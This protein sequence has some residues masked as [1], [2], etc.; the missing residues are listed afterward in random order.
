MPSSHST[1][2]PFTSCP[3]SEP[4]VCPSVFPM[5]GR[6]ALALSHEALRRHKPQEQLGTA[7]TCFVPI[8]TSQTHRD[9]GVCDTATPAQNGSASRFSQTLHHRWGAVSSVHASLVE[10]TE[11]DQAPGSKSSAV[12]LSCCPAEQDRGLGWH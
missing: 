2:N 6:G 11:D 4:R 7:S 3:P 8:P 12:L 10:S 9:K 5:G 1:N